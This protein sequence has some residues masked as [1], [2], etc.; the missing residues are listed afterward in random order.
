MGIK[1]VIKKVGEIPSI[2]RYEAD[3]KTMQ[4]HYGEWLFWQE[5]AQK[6]KEHLGNVDTEGVVI[7]NYFGN[8]PIR[9]I[10]YYFRFYPE[11]KILYGDEDAKGKDGSP[12]DP[13]F[14]PAWSPERLESCFYLGSLIAFRRSFL[15]EAMPD[16]KEILGPF[17]VHAQDERGPEDQGEEAAAA[18]GPAAVFVNETPEDTYRDAIFALC[19]KAGGWERGNQSIVH[20]PGI[21]HHCSSKERLHGFAEAF[22][23]YRRALETPKT[24]LSVV[25]L[26]KDHPELLNNCL[27]ALKRACAKRNDEDRLS[28]EVIV[29]DNGSKPENREQIERISG[30]TYLY[31]PMEFHFS[32]LCNMGAKA[33]KGGLLLFL[34]DDVELLPES[35]LAQMEALAARPG[36]GSVGIKLYYPNSTM[37][38][39]AGI[40][41]LSTGPVHKLLFLDDAREYYFGRNRG[42]HDEL[43]VSAACVM[44]RTEVFWEAGG[45]DESLPVAYNDVALGFRL[46][47]MGYR[48]VVTCNAHA[49]HHESLT[50]GSDAEEKKKERLLAEQ[51]KLYQLFPKLKGK[52]PYYSEF[53]SRQATDTHV[54]PFYETSKNACQSVIPKPVGDMP[55]IRLDPC[56]SVATQEE[57]NGEIIG[58][59]VVLGDDNA[60]YDRWILWEKETGERWYA[61]INGQYRPDL[62]E[63]MPD[64][65]HVELCGFWIYLE[66]GSL[67]PGK[68]R[69]GCYAKRKVGKLRLVYWSDRPLYVK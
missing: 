39:H 4:G 17:E 24:L 43:A 47:E 29:V 62:V 26:T 50:R 10:Q 44:L 9:A 11:T 8:R 57:R 55:G 35:K 5:H 65:T 12:E 41:N 31:E 32:K 36:V 13:W 61:K 21:L 60:C 46:Y 7:E 54:R 58:Y 25:I 40:T 23:R 34:N 16:W 42:W 3:L 6:M 22:S 48:N 64:Q 33:A 14:R 37:I 30:I 20:L 59:A 51:E 19:E 66:K 53:F 63:K 27:E 15:E 68:Y 49:Y 38:Q 2:I 69:I 1:S 52:D 67:P 56:L 28:Y 18:D 45:F